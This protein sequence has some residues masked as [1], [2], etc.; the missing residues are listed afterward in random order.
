MCTCVAMASTNVGKLG[1]GGAVAVFAAR[2]GRPC[3]GGAVR[4]SD[5]C[6]E[7]A[8]A[9]AVVDPTYPAYVASV[10]PLEHDRVCGDALRSAARAWL[11]TRHVRRDKQVRLTSA[12]I[13]ISSTH[14]FRH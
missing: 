3:R 12:H 7:A 8:P 4:K 9:V 5:F 13:F 10:A 2:Q 11:L 14:Y 1:V 6:L